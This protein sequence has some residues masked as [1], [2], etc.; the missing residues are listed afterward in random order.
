MTDFFEAPT[1]F[2]IY[3]YTLPETFDTPELITSLST[4]AHARQAELSDFEVQQLVSRRVDTQASIQSAASSILF[5][6]IFAA[7][8]YFSLN[9]TLMADVPPVLVDVIL[10]R[11][12]LNIF[13]QSLVPTAGYIIV[14]AIIG[15]FASRTIRLLLVQIAESGVAETSQ[16]LDIAE[17]KKA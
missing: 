16:Q 9:K 4:Y 1:A 7:A 13:P 3:T 10:D 8:D 11:Y 14:L 12:L 17:K 6:Q 15:W 5:V 2:W